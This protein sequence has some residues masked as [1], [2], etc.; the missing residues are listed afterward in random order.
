M[1]VNDSFL[2]GDIHRNWGPTSSCQLCD[3]PSETV[4]HVLFDCPALATW[5]PLHWDSV[6]RDNVLWGGKTDNELAVGV[7]RIFLK[8]AVGWLPDKRLV[9]LARSRRKGFFAVD[10]FAHPKRSYL[11]PADK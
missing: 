6:D 11:C 9:G 10:A 2:H 4:Q 7:M 1:R 5:R 8:L 3:S